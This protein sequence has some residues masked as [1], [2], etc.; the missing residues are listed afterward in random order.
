MRWKLVPVELTSKMAHGWDGACPE[1][2]A[3]ASVYDIAAADWNAFLDA[4]PD[5]AF[6]D[7]QLV[8][9]VA[10]ALATVDGQDPDG[11]DAS[12][13]CDANNRPLPIWM[14]FEEEAR[15]ALKAMEE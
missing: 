10:R 5:D 15:A 13:I 12:F 14:G 6:N 7:G 3:G 2:A 11:L 8:E 1:P 4:A 9:R